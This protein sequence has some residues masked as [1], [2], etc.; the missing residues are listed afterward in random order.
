M[1]FGFFLLTVN[2]ISRKITCA[3]KSCLLFSRGG[4]KAPWDY[5]S[6][7]VDR[8]G[9]NNEGLLPWQKGS[10]GA[11]QLPWLRNSQGRELL[12]WLRNSQGREL[13]PWLRNSQGR[14]LLP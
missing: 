10:S 6:S 1:D 13:L 2:K 9:G 7:L 3:F 12:P 14:E 11:E 5:S 4:V 8:S